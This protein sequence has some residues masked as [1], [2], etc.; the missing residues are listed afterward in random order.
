[1][2]KRE[3]VGM[4]QAMEGWKSCIADLGE[5]AEICRRAEERVRM[6]REALTQELTEED[7]QQAY[8]EAMTMSAPQGNF[9][10]GWDACLRVL[11]RRWVSGLS[12]A[13]T[14]EPPV[15]LVEQMLEAFEAQWGGSNT[16]R[17]AM[18]AALL[19]AADALLG[20]VTDEERKKHHELVGFVPAVA[21]I[22]LA[23]RR[24][25]LLTKTPEERVTIERGDAG[26]ILRKDGKLIGDRLSHEVATYA[27]IGLIA[28]LKG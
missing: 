21:D 8:E 20:P 1:M 25:R 22:F 13:Q 15:D 17:I 23:D 6:L 10:G 5:A 28:A 18:A 9:R 27:K 2:G 3:E 26:W 4:M 14:P 12:S 19:V 24:A 11:A 16:V 7:F